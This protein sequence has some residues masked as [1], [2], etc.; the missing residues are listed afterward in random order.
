M[1]FLRVGVAKAD[2][3]PPVGTRMAGYIQR[4]FVSKGIHDRLFAKVLY[5]SDNQTEAALV[6]ID[7][8]AVDRKLTRTIRD[9]IEQT[10]GIPG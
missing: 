2:I 3:T 5:L 8:L 9:R 4:R 1:S 10:M 7:S 6:S